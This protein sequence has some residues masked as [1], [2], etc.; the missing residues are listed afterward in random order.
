MG[1]ITSH[2]DMMFTF[3]S[4]RGSSA[5]GVC[6]GIGSP[7]MAPSSEI[8]AGSAG[9]VGGNATSGDC[10]GVAWEGVAVMGAGMTVE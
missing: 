2:G 9:P 7:E 5:I 10:R 6:S 3:R 4:N 1:S 8:R